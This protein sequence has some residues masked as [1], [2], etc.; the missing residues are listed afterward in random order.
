V[1]KDEADTWWITDADLV[2]GGDKETKYKVRRLTLDKHR[3]IQKRHTKPGNYRRPEGKVD[4]EA[5]QDDLFDYAL[6]NWE[7]VLKD[8]QP[9]ACEWEFKRLIDVA[10][11]I[12]ILDNAGLNDL[13]AAEDARSQSF[14]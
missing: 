4:G 5:I 12:A 6:D 9:V 8:G 3:E 11:R 1:L 2:S 14:R 7:G 10:R 13:A